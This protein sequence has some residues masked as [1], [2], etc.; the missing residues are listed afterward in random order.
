MA[1][2]RRRK[3][4]GNRAILVPKLRWEGIAA[5]FLSQNFAGKVSRH[6]SCPKTSLG[7][8]RGTILVPKLRWE[9]IAA[10]FLSQI[11]AGK[12]SRRDSCPKTSL[13]RYRGT[14]LVPKLRWEE[15]YARI[16]SQILAGKEF[17]RVSR[18][19]RM[20]GAAISVKMVG[21]ARLWIHRDSAFCR[22]FAAGNDGNATP[23]WQEAWH[24]A[25]L[26]IWNVRGISVSSTKSCRD[27]FL[28]LGTRDCRMKLAIAEAWRFAETQEC[29]STGGRVFVFCA[30]SLANR[31]WHGFHDSRQ[32]RRG[33]PRLY[34]VRA[35]R[36]SPRPLSAAPFSRVF[37]E[38]IAKK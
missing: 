10:R 14:I 18:P 7:R 2:A 20:A 34:I 24:A 16:S 1:D 17:T 5:Q 31:A 27:A 32:G 29:V 36:D 37:R 6:D 28:R 3:N 19:S 8:Y 22:N 23:D 21:F 35:E 12:V 15:I 11:F 30:A 13:G 33:A 26:A 9:G 4:V 38:I 25:S